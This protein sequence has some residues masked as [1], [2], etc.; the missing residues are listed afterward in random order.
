MLRLGEFTSGQRLSLSYLLVLKLSNMHK[1]KLIRLVMWTKDTD[2]NLLFFPVQSTGV[3]D[4]KRH[5]HICFIQIWLESFE[6]FELCVLFWIGEIK[7]VLQDL[8]QEYCTWFPNKSNPISVCHC[9]VGWGDLEWWEGWN[10]KQCR[11]TVCLEE[12]V[13]RT[14]TR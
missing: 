12:T 14:W 13:W 1:A 5:S 2:N 6:I 4:N 9:V 8:C 3:T 10:K 11:D 7:N